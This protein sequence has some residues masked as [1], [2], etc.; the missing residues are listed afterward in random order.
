MTD[1]ENNSG[2]ETGVIEY[3]L[4][5][6]LAVVAPDYEGPNSEFLAPIGEAHGVV[7]GIKAPFGSRRPTSARG[8]RS[9][10]GVIQAARLP[11]CS[12]PDNCAAIPG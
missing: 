1:A 10:C 9:R 11:P 12:P 4:L 3:A 2:A 8:R 5:R 7:D 6:G